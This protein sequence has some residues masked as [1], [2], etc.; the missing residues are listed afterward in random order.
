MKGTNDEYP[1]RLRWDRLRRQGQH[2]KMIGASGAMCQ[3][4]FEDGFTALVSR[5]AIV[6]R[7]APPKNLLDGKPVDE[8]KL[9]ASGLTTDGVQEKMNDGN[10][11]R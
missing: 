9:A 1:H 11:V 3:V 8:S 4:E 6:R 5:R 10:S 2:C 7:V